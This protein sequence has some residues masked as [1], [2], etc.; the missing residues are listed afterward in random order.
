M[1]HGHACWLQKEKYKIVFFS[2]EYV[3][4]QVEGYQVVYSTLAGE[5]YDKVIVPRNEGAT[6]KTA[7]TG[8]WAHSSNT[9][10]LSILKSLIINA[11][12]FLSSPCVVLLVYL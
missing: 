9:A 1:W 7:L 12:M 3:F 8:K 2:L 5:Q 10:S 6:T 11:F 4:T